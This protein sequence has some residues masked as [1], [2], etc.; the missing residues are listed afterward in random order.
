MNTTTT[1]LF[2]W[3]ITKFVK[4]RFYRGGLMYIIHID[5]QWDKTWKKFQFQMC[6]WL[7]AQWPQRLKLTLCIW[8]KFLHSGSPLLEIFS[9]NFILAFEASRQCIVLPKRTFFD[10]ILEYP[11]IILS[12]SLYPQ[13]YI[14]II[15][16]PIILSPN[17]ISPIHSI[18]KFSIPV[19]FYP[20]FETF[21]FLGIEWIGDRKF[22]DIMNWG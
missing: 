18:P 11:Q 13:N 9:K 16:S 3:Q 8:K 2:P 10:Y 12:P 19:S 4:S 22:G 7:V 21:W 1:Y 20:P 15:L 6:V 14:P 17:F 5:S